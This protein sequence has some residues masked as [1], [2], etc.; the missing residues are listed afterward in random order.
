M[1]TLALELVG[2]CAHW[3]A[4]QPL[5]ILLPPTPPHFPCL[6]QVLK[7]I[8]EQLNSMKE[9]DEAQAAWAAGQLEPLR[10]TW[11]LIRILA[12]HQGSLIGRTAASGSK[13]SRS[14][15]AG[16]T[17]PVFHTCCSSTIPVYEYICKGPGCGGGWCWA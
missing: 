3:P 5:A 15:N 11:Q 14:C 7:F 2:T 9:E 10:L 4:L 6:T 17:A 1:K 12:K 8:A 16:I 13:V